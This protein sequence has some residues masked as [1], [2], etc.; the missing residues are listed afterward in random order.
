M[1]GANAP[2]L[3]REQMGAANPTRFPE[4]HGQGQGDR[5]V[6]RRACSC[7]R[8]LTVG[9]SGDGSAGPEGLDGAHVSYKMLFDV[10]DGVGDLLGR[11]ARS[12]LEYR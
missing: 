10:P 3:S 6:D 12:M 9:R 8:L 7:S 4:Y 2:I 5:L 1:S 11:Y